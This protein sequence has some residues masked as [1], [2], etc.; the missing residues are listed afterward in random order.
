MN[1]PQAQKNKPKQ[2]QFQ[3]LKMLEF[4]LDFSSLA[5]LSGAWN[6]IAPTVDILR[7][8]VD[9]SLYYNKLQ[10]HS[11]EFI[12]LKGITIVFCDFLAD[13]ITLKG[14]TLKGAK[15]SFYIHG[16]RVAF[17]FCRNNPGDISLPARTYQPA[18]A[19]SLHRNP[20]YQASGLAAW[21]SVSARRPN[22]KSQSD[23][24]YQYPAP[25]D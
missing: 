21:L 24:A 23:I 5:F 2:T 7:Y 19:E 8:C 16:N 3:R 4:T 10:F 1:H 22:R 12:T 13:F 18:L 17:W 14:A 20:Y 9:K 6:S 11:R 25:G 15:I